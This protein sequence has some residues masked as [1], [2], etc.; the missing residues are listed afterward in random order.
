MPTALC[1]GSAL[2][3]G[4]DVLLPW[5]HIYPASEFFAGVASTAEQA[6][7]SGLDESSALLLGRVDLML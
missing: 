1:R 5:L 2:H 3:A 6:A 4:D 7:I